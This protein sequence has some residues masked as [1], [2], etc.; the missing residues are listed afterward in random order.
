MFVL[1]KAFLF[2]LSHELLFQAGQ[3][4]EVQFFARQFYGDSCWV[5]RQLRL[6]HLLFGTDLPM[7]F[8]FSDFLQPLEQFFIEKVFVFRIFFAILTL[9][10]LL[11][12]FLVLLVELILYLWNV[13]FFL[14]H[15]EDLGESI[16][17]LF[18][19][20][21]FEVSSTEAKATNLKDYYESCSYSHSH[22][23]PYIEIAGCRAV[24]FEASIAGK[25]SLYEFASYNTRCA[26][27]API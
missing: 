7:L 9:S 4:I 14:Q 12:I 2:L 11:E 26:L 17:S 8:F 10:S 27:V 6:F 20:G 21:G 1:A 22:N 18:F 24:Q 19:M 16:L 25:T 5:G 3:V 23:Q 13:S 15:L